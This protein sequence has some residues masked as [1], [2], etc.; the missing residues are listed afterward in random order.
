MNF[1]IKF[2]KYILILSSYLLILVPASCICHIVTILSVKNNT[3]N[4]FL[5]FITE[6]MI[7]FLVFIVPA[8]FLILTIFLLLYYFLKTKTK[9]IFEWNLLLILIYGL[10]IVLTFL[11]DIITKNII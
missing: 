9:N 3:P 5:F 10:I 11:T 6:K 7:T 2:H 1:W 4:D 8:L